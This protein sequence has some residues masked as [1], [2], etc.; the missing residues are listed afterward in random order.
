MT[1][2]EAAPRVSAT[3]SEDATDPTGLG[4][5]VSVA[6]DRKGSSKLRCV[7]VYVLC[8]NKG[9]FSTYQQQVRW[10]NEQGRTENPRK[11]LEIDFKLTLY[12][13]IDEGD[14][15]VVMMD[16]NQDVRNSSF[17]RMLNQ[18]GLYDAIL[19]LH[20]HQTPP[21]RYTLRK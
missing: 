12:N 4:R 15:I 13:W 14:D 8:F 2:N 20:G 5:W 19:S 1:A 18:L 9:F 7:S 10:L 3:K 17:T 6:L 11:A 16:A 21:A